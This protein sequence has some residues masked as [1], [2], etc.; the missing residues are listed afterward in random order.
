MEAS[1]KRHDRCPDGVP[2]E[3]WNAFLERY[4]VDGFPGGFTFLTFAVTER[5]YTIGEALLK[6]GEPV[7]CPDC[8]GGFPLG[9]AVALDDPVMVRLLCR[10]G[11]NLHGKHNPLW[12][13]CSGNMVDLLVE[14]GA[15]PRE[16]NAEGYTALHYIDFEIGDEL[17]SA[18]I[19]H[20]ADVNAL[21]HNGTTPLWE[22]HAWHF[23][24]EAIAMLK[25]WGARLPEELENKNDRDYGQDDES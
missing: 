11:A 25:R 7:N 6:R 22:A 19:R 8:K 2:V 1:K 16:C 23:S 24:E 10:N 20:G 3:D 14:L 17:L 12:R 21:T 13:V 9:R 18:F 5:N 15:D 4:L